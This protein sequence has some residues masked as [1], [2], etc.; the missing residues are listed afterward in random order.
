MKIS[1]REEE[2]VV[3]AREAAA[4]GRLRDLRCG[5][6]LTQAEAGSLCGVSGAAVARWEGHDR[7]PRGQA[8]IALGRLI[9]RLQRQA[10]SAHS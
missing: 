10:A 6:R 2:L 8:A 9:E 7:V 3:L 1:W 5:A 4:T